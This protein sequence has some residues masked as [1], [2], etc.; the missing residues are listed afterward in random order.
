M[1]PAWAQMPSP[2]TTVQLQ[3]L[4]NSRYDVDA[5]MC[6]GYVT[7]VAERLMIDNNPHQR[8]CL[9]PAIAPQILVDNIRNV[10]A[11]QPPEAQDLAAQTVESALRQQFRCP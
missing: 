1:M 7:A 2:M 10:W 5:G 4:C 8:V 9:S 11:K 3:D 6:A